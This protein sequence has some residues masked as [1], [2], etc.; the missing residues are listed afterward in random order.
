MNNKMQ[1]SIYSLIFSIF[2]VAF[3]FSLSAQ[4]SISQFNVPYQDDF[5]GFD[6]ED[7]PAG[8]VTS[9]APSAA[10]SVWRGSGTGSSAT[11]GKW[12]YGDSGAGGSFD[13]SLGFLPSSTRAI[14]ADISFENNTGE[15]ITTLAINYVAE[16]WRSAQNGRFNGWTVTYNPGESDE[17]AIPSMT[18]VA[19]NNNPT[20]VNPDGGP[21]EA[22]SLSDTLTGLN[23]PDGASFTIR[24][25]GD[26][27]TGEDARQGVAID[28][29]SLTA[30]GSPPS[31]DPLIFVVPGSLS[32]F[33]YEEANGPSTSQS[34]ELSGSEL[35]PASG[36]LTVD[37]SGTD[38]E[39]SLDDITFESSVDVA[40]SGGELAGTT[41]YVRLKEGLD[42]GEYNNQEIM[43]SGGGA[44]AATL[45]LNGEVTSAAVVLPSL[46][47]FNAPYEEDFADF[48]DASTLP[49]GWSPDG[50]YSYGGAFPGGTAGGLR[51]AG[52]LGFQLTGSAP[53]NNF[54]AKL[55]LV[56]DIGS[57]IENLQINY[58]G[59]VGFPNREGTPKWIV[60]VDGEEIEALE[61]STESGEDELKTF[62]LTGLNIANGAT[63]EIEWFTTATGTSGQRRQIGLTNVEIVAMDEI[64]VPDAPELDLSEG[65]YFEDQTVFVSNFG[66]YASSVEVRYTTDGSAPNSSSDLYNDVTGISLED[67]NG[68]ILLRAIAI[69]NNTTQESDE[70]LAEYVFP[71]NV[72]NIAEFRAGTGGELYRITGEVVL[73]YVASF[74]NRHFIR[75]GSGSMIVFDQGGN[76]S[77]TYSPGEGISGFIGERNTRNSGA[78]EVMEAITNPGPATSFGNDISPVALSFDELSLDFTG[79]LVEVSS[80]D[81]TSD[82]TFS[83]GTT[84][85]MTD[86]SIS[87]E[88]Q[89]RTDFFDADYIGE[90][91]PE[92]TVNLTALVI[93]FGS[94][95]QLVAR[96]LED[97]EMVL[98]PIFIEPVQVVDVNCAGG[99]DG[100]IELN[101]SGGSGQYTFNWSGPGNFQSD[102]QNIDNLQAG[103][104]S[105]TVVDN[106]GGSAV[107]STNISQPSAPELIFSLNGEVLNS[108][109]VIQ[110]PEGTELSLVLEEVV[111]GA[112]PFE[113]SWSLESGADQFFGA[114]SGQSTGSEVFTLSPPNG[115]YTLDLND[116]VDADNCPNTSE[117][118]LFTVELISIEELEFANFLANP[119]QTIVAPGQQFEVSIEVQL[120][121][122]TASAAEAHLQF[123]P[124][125][126]EVVSIEAEDWGTGEDQTV[127]FNDFDNSQGTIDFG[128]FQLSGPHPQNTTFGFFTITFL[129][130]ADVESTEVFHLLETDF[131]SEISYEGQPMLK[132]AQSAF[133]TIDQCLLFELT[134]ESIPASCFNNPD[135]SVE[136]IPVMGTAPFVF[137]WETGHDDA[138][139]ENVL[140]GSYALTVTDADGCQETGLFEVG[141]IPDTEAPVVTCSVKEV[142]VDAEGACAVPIVD[143]TH[144][145]S[146]TDNCTAEEDLIFGQIPTSGLTQIA[147]SITVF[148]TATDESGNTGFCSFL[149]NLENFGDEPA[150]MCP[151][152]E[153]VVTND[154][155]VCE[156]FVEISVE[157]VT[158][159]EGGTITNSV[160]G[161]GPDA[162]GIYPLG[163]NEVIFELI[164]ENEVIFSCS[165]N[166]VVQDG[167]QPVPFVGVP[168]GSLQA[169]GP[170]NNEDAACAGE[171][172]LEAPEASTSCVGSIFAVPSSS[173]GLVPGSNPPT[174]LFTSATFSEGVNVIWTFTNPNNELSVTQTQFIQVLEPQG[175]SI[176]CPSNT[177]IFTGLEDCEAPFVP[178]QAVAFDDCSDVIITNDALSVYPIGEHQVTYTATSESGE[179]VS[180]VQTI[181]AIDTVPPSLVCP[182]DITLTTNDG[183]CISEYELIQ[184]EVFENC[185][186]GNQF[187]DFSGTLELGEST[188]TFTAIDHS[189]NSSSCTQTIT[190]VD[191]SLPVIICPADIV[192]E[193]DAGLCEAS[194]IDPGLAFASYTCGAVVEI[195]NDAPEV[196]PVGT[197]V[198]NHTATAENGQIAQCTQNVQIIDTQ[199]PEI[200]CPDDVVVLAPAGESEVFIELPETMATDNCGF[201]IENNQNSNGADASDFYPIGITIVV[202]TATDAAGLGDTC[203]VSIQVNAEF[204]PDSA[205]ISGNVSTAFGY[206]VMDTELKFGGGVDFSVFSDESGNYSAIVPEGL[207]INVIPERDFDWMNGV[208]TL[209][210]VLA[211]RHILLIDTLQGPYVLIGLD[212]NQDD[213]IS[214]FDLVLIQNLIIEGGSLGIPGIESVLFVPADF[215]FTDDQNPFL[216]SYPSFRAYQAIS[217]DKLDQDWI[218]IKV[219]DA[220]GDAFQPSSRE[221]RLPLPVY[222]SVEQTENGTI[223][224]RI[225]AKE[226]S[227]LSG[228]Q[229]EFEYDRN[230]MEWLGFEFTD[231]ELENLGEMNFFHDIESGIIRA[232]WWMGPGQELNFGDEFFRMSF[233]MRGNFDQEKFKEAFQLRSSGQH[234]NS[235]IYKR[236]LDIYR[237]HLVWS[238]YRDAS[239]YV[240]HQNEPNPFTG[241][242]IIPFELPLDTEV[243]IE[244]R[245]LQ[246]KLIHKVN[247]PGMEGYNRYQ[248][249]VQLMSAGI[250][251]YRLITE[252]WQ[253]TR[254]MIIAD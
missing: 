116:F 207:N 11:G 52:V 239:E 97:F 187:N 232:N 156:A 238:E 19:Q 129:A 220:N 184:P 13:G 114:S 237:P 85:F 250:Y 198:V 30:V 39:V 188:I 68:A 201:T 150:L 170:E 87:G 209:D 27:G 143:Y 142:L 180:C 139:L 146:A 41:I 120:S 183:S 122:L 163:S 213:V 20:G 7:D 125:F 117:D 218:A 191:E 53:N 221:E 105:L 70:T 38:Y 234:W 241:Q 34:F 222:A 5:T 40:Y 192:L 172:I 31:E 160:T 140:P 36:E 94:N 91:I 245:D 247:I 176:Q 4:I 102:Q 59:K 26:N 71:V 145:A 214:T 9:D 89:F 60:R 189:A 178:G 228:Y 44:D 17:A 51:G 190:L 147:E 88:A 208:T 164:E 119:S 35:E 202:F 204:V 15:L 111:N 253:A 16:H 50:T 64:P 96:S 194:G 212:V 46:T 58:L 224:L 66:T 77:T 226:F 48:V 185:G 169:V 243:L 100:L 167:D 99:S 83:T 211:Q 131:P 133:I 151:P 248:L 171:I 123:D 84:Y 21:W 216:D 197:T 200:S 37:A 130:L 159:C 149:L 73:L 69:D 95:F 136:V 107:F 196:F 155:G 177:F 29:F 223:D 206:P 12:S 109:D 78:L 43:V 74:Q 25:F 219:G 62:I 124:D 152:S 65:T 28:D 72:A 32:G 249:D 179:S 141:F 112:S 227:T 195:S 47:A 162:S 82:G 173:D 193:A 57:S 1:N 61:Y 225:A 186:I 10:E 118:Y 154:P 138:V 42:V 166:V 174:Y 135:G 137:E 49:N 165:T 148:I 175:P 235:E 236:S 86:P 92:N 101:V 153:I 6:G 110:L 161:S 210:L 127:I 115:I 90:A 252:E 113:I 103:N 75:D 55:E 2:F 98:D 217:S 244:I 56:N 14:Y 80:V 121:L 132:D 33:G 203:L 242:T 54:T 229:F 3:S 79:N 104:Y 128:A 108:V 157:F 254:K 24:F 246:G 126:L 67:G 22:V 18:Y 233:E 63:I 8:W 134:S 76:I 106:A 158:G 23:I 231:S 45:T 199:A 230:Q 81:F 240:L 93:G 251:F 144:L 181:F 168:G 215:E 182:E 205:I